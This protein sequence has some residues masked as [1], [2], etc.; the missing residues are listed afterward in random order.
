MRLRHFLLLFLVPVLRPH[1]PAKEVTPPA[2]ILPITVEEIGPAQAAA[3]LLQHQETLI[4]DVRTEDERRTRGHI[5]NSVHHDYF[6]GQKT[7]AALE[8]LDK[9]RPCLLYC[10]MGGRAKRMAV[11]LNKL[12]FQHLWVLK[13]GFNGW[14]AEG[15]AVAK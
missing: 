7:L 9:T 11:E 10:A 5:L 12:G 6:G 15:L 3:F 4:L 8:S 2:V 1:L 13:G 14:V